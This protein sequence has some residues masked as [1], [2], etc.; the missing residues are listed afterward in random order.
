MNVNLEIRYFLSTTKSIM[1]SFSYALIHSIIHF[2]TFPHGAFSWK[3]TD[4]EGLKV[5][6]F[7]ALKASFSR[8]FIACLKTIV[9]ESNIN[10]N[11]QFRVFV[12]KMQ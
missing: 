7:Q 12:K 6:E 9:F 10:S 11:A 8:F 1:Q 5:H 3:V 4:S 2:A